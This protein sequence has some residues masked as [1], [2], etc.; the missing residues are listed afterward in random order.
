MQKLV[1]SSH[2]YGQS[3]FHI[4]FCPKFRHDVLDGEIEHEVYEQFHDIAYTWDMKIR[5][6]KINP[7]HVHMFVSLKSW[8]SPAYA[9]HK[10]KGISARRVFQK[11]PW[12]AEYKKGEKR[13]WG[14]ELW[15]DGYFYRSVGSVTDDAVEFYIKVSQDKHLRNKFY[16]KVGSESKNAECC[17][18]P[19]V[20]FLRDKSQISLKGFF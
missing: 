13:F 8:Q 6:V 1:S 16:T 10:F 17:E 2:S 15:S 5:V 4:V 3:W 14:R 20:K 19:L 9:M 12:L 11:F 18:D 7:D